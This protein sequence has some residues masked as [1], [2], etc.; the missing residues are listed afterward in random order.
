MAGGIMRSSDWSREKDS[1]RKLGAEDKQ[2][3]DP[4]EEWWVFIG[5]DGT[6]QGNWPARDLCLVKKKVMVSK[7]M[8]MKQTCC[9]FENRPREKWEEREDTDTD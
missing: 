7:R 1:Q 8:E 9:D 6:F 2:V 5:P 4:I 3:K